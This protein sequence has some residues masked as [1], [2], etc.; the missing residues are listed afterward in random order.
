MYYSFQNGLYK[1][2]LKKQF[3]DQYRITF[4]PDLQR[5]DLPASSELEQVAAEQAA[6]EQAAA[7]L[8]SLTLPL[9]L[10]CMRPFPDRQLVYFVFTGY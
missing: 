4:M 2:T 8:P 9:F 3:S 5:R 10:C 7:A 6:T 1:K